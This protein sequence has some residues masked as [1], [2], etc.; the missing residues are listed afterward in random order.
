MARLIFDLL[1]DPFDLLFDFSH[2]LSWLDNVK[3]CKKL[4]KLFLVDLVDSADLL[5]EGNCYLDVLLDKHLLL[6]LWAYILCRGCIAS[7]VFLVRVVPRSLLCPNY[8][9]RIRI[10]I[11]LWSFLCFL[12][13][14]DDLRKASQ[15]LFS[16]IKG[17]QNDGLYIFVW[18]C[19]AK[20]LF[21]KYFHKCQGNKLCPRMLSHQEE[22]RVVL[23]WRIHKVW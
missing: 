5:Q 22:K 12:H 17:I 10:E 2:L 18:F 6:A 14:L 19:T 8:S 1:N 13:L 23:E 3:D 21:F 16:V 9:K 20:Q 15:T 4:F 7:I 11:F